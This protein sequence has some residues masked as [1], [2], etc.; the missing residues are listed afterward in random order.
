MCLKKG[1]KLYSIANFKCP[2]C[3]EG[4]FFL[5][6]KTWNLSKLTTLH[7]NCPHCNLKYMLEPSF[8]YGAMY[9]AYGLTVGIAIVVFLI[10]NLIFKLALWESFIAISVLLLLGGP[11]NL[12]IARIIWIN[13]FVGFDEKFLKK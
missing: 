12:R 8:Y 10:S 1:S 7:S 11:I 5:H 3:H 13:I 6:K 4:D 2:R 9:V